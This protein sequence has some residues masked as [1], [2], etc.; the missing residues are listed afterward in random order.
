MII[1]G[2]IKLFGPK[3]IKQITVDKTPIIAGLWFFWDF[4]CPTN[5]TTKERLIQNQLP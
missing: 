3:I 1:E 5:I 2:I 4:H